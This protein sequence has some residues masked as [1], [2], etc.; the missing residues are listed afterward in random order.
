MN[1]IIA[2]L[3]GILGLVAGVFIAPQLSPDA[4][5]PEP[6]A[7]VMANDQEPSSVDYLSARP[8]VASAPSSPLSDAERASIIFM[9]EEEKLA[10][11]VYT[12]LYE[13]WGLPIFTN[14]A[15]SEQT[16]TEAVRTLLEKYAVPDP[17]AD[18]TIGVFVNDDLR[19][20]Y[21]R[22][23]E[24]G[25]RSLE[26][27][28]RV[29]AMIEDLDLKDLATQS[30]SV[31]NEDILFVNDNLARG[32]RNHLRAF[33]RQLESRGTTYTPQ[34]IS[35]SEYQAIIASDRETGGKGMKRG[36]GN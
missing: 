10:R 3:I 27:A 17:V 31:D 18:D 2:S 24:E 23:T 8:Y 22:L 6:A 12:V 15:Q 9:R 14:I 20:L 13:R 28:L 35:E 21:T 4:P 30:A 29:G 25:S 33:V 1:T 32:S 16:H 34:Y 26:D 5:P 11:D 7:A 19:A 36:W